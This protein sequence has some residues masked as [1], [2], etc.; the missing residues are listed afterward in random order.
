MR[1][2]PQP[3]AVSAR[4]PGVHELIAERAR[5]APD[6]VAVVHRSER[7]SYA[8]LGARSARLAHHLLARRLPHNP[9]VAIC[10]QRSTAL[11]HS[12]LGVLSAG[13]AYLPLDPEHPAERLAFVLHDSGASLLLTEPSLLDRI[14]HTG[15]PTLLVDDPALAAGPDSPPDVR[16]HPQDLAYA[17]YTSGSTGRP[18]GVAIRHAGLTNHL[19]TLRDVLGVGEDDVMA[20]I[21]TIGFDISGLELFL[22]LIAG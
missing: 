2:D 7:L 20:A 1:D 9:L 11:V 18:K 5:L 12:I 14:P 22:P 13:A 21:A 6:R 16:V 8:D 3:P 4:P 10:L 17:I 15:I 19:L